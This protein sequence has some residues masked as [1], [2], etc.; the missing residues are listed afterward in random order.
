LKMS[1]LPNLALKSP[2]KIFIGCLEF[3]KY[4]F[5][6]LPLTQIKG[7]VALLCFKTLLGWT[8]L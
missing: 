1:S 2:S 6:A 7:N 3:I 4:L 5:Q 8:D